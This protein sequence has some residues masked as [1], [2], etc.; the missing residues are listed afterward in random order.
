MKSGLSPQLIM[1]ASL[2]RHVKELTD[3]GETSV[4]R[5]E[6][7]EAQRDSGETEIEC[8]NWSSEYAEQGYTAGPRGIL[9]ANWNYFTR[10]VI[11]ILERA[12][13]DTQ[14]SDE[15]STCEECGKLVRTSGDSYY[16]QPSYVIMNECCIVCLACVDW[17][18]Y[19]ESIED[20]PNAAVVQACDP[21]KYGYVLVSQPHEYE[22]GWHPGQNDN[23]AKVLAKLQGT[24]HKRVVFRIPETSQFYIKWE[25]WEKQME[26]EDG[27]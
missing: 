15:W 10:D 20:N 14:W 1:R 5:W 11:D 2:N 27:E 7:P 9:L 4:S 12:G 22:T 21:E 24:G 6:T 3:S 13:F 16:W 18:E 23:P 17:E 26:S 19:L 8:L 25:V